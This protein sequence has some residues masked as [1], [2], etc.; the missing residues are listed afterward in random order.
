MD[1]LL[2][3]LLGFLVGL[4]TSFLTWWILAHWI[5]PK[6]EFSKDISKLKTEDDGSGYM[7]RIK[8][9]NVGR[10]GLIDMQVV[11]RLLIKG[12]SIPRN[13]VTIKIP[14]EWNGSYKTEI[15]KLS[16]KSNRIIRLFLSSSPDLQM[17]SYIPEV[18]RDKARLGKLTLEELLSLGSRAKLTIWVF[19]Y[20]EFSGA[21]KLFKSYEYQAEDIKDGRFGRLE[22]VG[23]STDPLPDY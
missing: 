15:P 22:V 11:A 20:D 23:S 4:L 18:I 2:T 10:R 13:W 6:I 16:A 17:N 9:I 14:L 19:G 8:F 1:N 21:R 3:N 7:Y 5:I 12:L